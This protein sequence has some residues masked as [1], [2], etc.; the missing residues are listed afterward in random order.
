[1]MPVMRMAAMPDYYAV[2]TRA[3]ADLESHDA[4]TRAELYERARNIIA[5]ELRKQN[6]KISASAIARE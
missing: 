1:M 4:A 3:L 2:L 6:P 5:A